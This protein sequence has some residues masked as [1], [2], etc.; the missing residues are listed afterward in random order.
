MKTAA[1][2]SMGTSITANAAINA[3]NSEQKY[4]F[5]GDLHYAKFCK[6]I[7]TDDVSMFKSSVRQKM[8]ELAANEKRVLRLLLSDHG[9]KCDGENLVEFSIQ[10]DAPNVYA[11]FSKK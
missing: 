2:L 11:Y 4:R 8:D 9:V 10:R 3:D 1:M 7:L 6:A 5:A